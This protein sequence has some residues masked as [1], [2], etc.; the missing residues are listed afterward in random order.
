MK[1]NTLRLRF[2]SDGAAVPIGIRVAMIEREENGNEQQS[3]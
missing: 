3:C 2:E 1:R